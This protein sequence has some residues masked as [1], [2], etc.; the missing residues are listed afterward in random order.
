M[1][2]ETELILALEMKSSLERIS[3]KLDRAQ[4]E[5]KIYIPTGTYRKTVKLRGRKFNFS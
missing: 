4:P 3:E 5:S 2:L 1:D